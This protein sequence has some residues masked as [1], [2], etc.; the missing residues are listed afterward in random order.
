[1]QAYL[2]SALILP[3]K[4]IANKNKVKII[5]INKIIYYP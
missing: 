2:E 5:S 1:M 4:A 3:F